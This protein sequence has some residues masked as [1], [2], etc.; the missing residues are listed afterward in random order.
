MLRAPASPTAMR[1]MI[2]TRDDHRHTPRPRINAPAHKN[3]GGAT[4]E[5]SVSRRWRSRR[6]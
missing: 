6:Q 5:L 3:A 4:K 2:L 1:H